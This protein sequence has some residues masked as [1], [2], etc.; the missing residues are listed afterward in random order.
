MATNHQQFQI[1]LT[2][3]SPLHIGNGE[4]LTSVGE[5][6]Q[7]N[8]N[9]YFLRHEDLMEKLKTD[10]HFDDYVERILTHDQ[11]FDFFK[12]LKDWDITPADFA[13]RTLRLNQKDINTNSNNKL[14]LHIKTKGEAYV[15]GSSIKGM[16]RTSI[17]FRYLKENPQE[18]RTIE[19]D[20][21]QRLSEKNTL[22]TVRHYWEKKERE[23]MPE[24]VFQSIRPYDTDCVSDDKLVIEQTYR[25]SLSQESMD[26][27]KGLDWLS[28][29]IDKGVELPLEMTICSDFENADF[30]YLKSST[31]KPLFNCI[32]EY[33]KK[34]IIQERQLVNT[35]NPLPP[36]KSAL[37]VQL[38]QYEDLLSTANDDYAIARMGKGKTIFFQTIIPLLKMEV[39]D[40]IL[41]LL[42]KEPGE[43]P[44]TRVLTVQDKQMMGWVK[45]E[46]IRPELKLPINQ[47]EGMVNIGTQLRAIITGPK[48]VGLILNG[49]PL[50]NV[51]LIL[52]FKHQKLTEGETINVLVHQMSK[53]GRIIQVKFNT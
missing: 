22:R 7:T 24:K 28:E 25:Q 9:V 21:L 29:C 14:H 34:L 53:D 23:L 42:K 16:L 8:D 49:S 13:I 51:S 43:F 5:F 18:L 2:T 10:N 33:T 50:T 44:R 30:K 41:N 3:F 1:K 46:E 48:K 37:L 39:Q 32:N 11:G 35:A 38:Q 52:M 47:M 20:I 17:L 27:S 36:I 45:L 15:P 4:E 40:A 26:A 6:L 12:T 31:L 19:S